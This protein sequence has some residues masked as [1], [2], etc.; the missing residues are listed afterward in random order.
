[1]SKYFDAD[2]YVGVN[3][4]ISKF[5]A[6]HPAGLINTFLETL[7]D[8]VYYKA[9]VFRNL[10]EAKLY[11]PIAA[12]AGHAEVSD[13]GK[14]SLEKAETVAIGRALAILGYDVKKGLASAEEMDDAEP[15]SSAPSRFGKAK[16]A[17][18][19]EASQ[20]EEEVSNVS[21]FAKKE[22]ESEKE[23]AKEEAAPAKVSRFSKKEEAKEEA[24]PTD[25][26]AEESQE[27][28]TKLKSNR[29]FKAGSR[30][31]RGA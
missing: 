24:A 11:P 20:P 10:E 19:G 14:K 8:R 2:N 7:G 30:F 18:K 15:K 4:R 3:E 29:P 17:S 23:E 25:S 21:R 16:V 26:Q 1:M 13:D 5:R 28:E 6:E 12:A 22:V 27:A 31:T 9:V